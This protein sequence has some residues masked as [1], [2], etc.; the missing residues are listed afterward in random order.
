MELDL[1]DGGGALFK[2][3][4]LEGAVVADLP[5]DVDSDK[6]LSVFCH[7]LAEL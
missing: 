4:V 7:V 6:E 5:V 2:R 1:G 3:D